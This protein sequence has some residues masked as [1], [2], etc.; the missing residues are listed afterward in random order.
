[1]WLSSHCAISE[2]GRATMPMRRKD[3]E[4]VFPDGYPDV[5]WLFVESLE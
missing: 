2:S 1:V 3:V 5:D 4:G